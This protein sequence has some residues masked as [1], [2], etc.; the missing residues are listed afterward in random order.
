MSVKDQFSTSQHPR[1][2]V[3][4]HLFSCAFAFAH[5]DGECVDRLK[6]CRVEN[7]MV[8]K[9]AALVD[10]VPG[11]VGKAAALENSID[12]APSRVRILHVM[13][14]VDEL[15]GCVCAASLRENVYVDQVFLVKRSFHIC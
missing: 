5:V 3:S 7:N 9:A 11:E 4:A 6:G 15:R 8:G 13:L 10:G 2:V 12:N 14:G 1:R